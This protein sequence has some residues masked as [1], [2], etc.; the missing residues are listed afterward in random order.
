M[1][2]R[3]LLPIF[4]LSC[5]IFSLHLFALA[6]FFYWTLWW[7]DI[8]V[9]TLGGVLISWIAIALFEKY[10]ISKIEMILLYGGFVPLLIS[11]GWEIFEFVSGITFLSSQYSLDTT[12]DITMGVLGGIIGSTLSVYFFKNFASDASN[13]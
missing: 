9:H 1:K 3:L 6:Y 4:F 13:V 7:F 5:I 11:I 10:K 8:L 2:S 12:L